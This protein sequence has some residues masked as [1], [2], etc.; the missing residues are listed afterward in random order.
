MIETYLG[1]EVD[2]E[3]KVDREVLL[4]EVMLIDNSLKIMKFKVCKESMKSVK[5]W[6]TLD[7]YPK[8]K[9][10]THTKHREK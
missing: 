9:L 8:F 7:I 4:H 6:R 3:L 1:V 5:R 2:L 10:T